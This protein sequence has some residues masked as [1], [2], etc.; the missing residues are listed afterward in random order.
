M[1]VRAQWGPMVEN[2]LIGRRNLRGVV[3]ILDARHPPTPDDLQL[4]K[5]LEESRI[6]AIPV[7][8]KVDKIGRA[9]WEACL[10][11]A[12]VSIGVQR[13]RLIDLLQRSSG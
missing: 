2:Y 8:T 3:H 7:L 4:W 13:G 5:W 1:N 10:G 12:S 9:K 11:Q 6:P